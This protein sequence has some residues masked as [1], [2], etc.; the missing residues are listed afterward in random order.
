MKKI[1]FVLL[2]GVLFASCTD[3]CVEDSK[4]VPA[5]FFVEM[6]NETTGENVFEN[7]SFVENDVEIT[8]VIGNDVLYNFIEDINTMQ[9]FPKT[10]IDA[11]NIQIKITLNNQTTMVTKELIVK[12][13]VASK[14]EE[15]YTSYEF[16]NILFPNN[17][18]ELVDGVFKV[19]I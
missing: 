10:T 17:L 3:K 2:I 9:L 6:I 5:T 18:S 13:N 16:T 7:G 19:K 15:C 8:D 12:Y 4:P 11:N 14:K 1:F